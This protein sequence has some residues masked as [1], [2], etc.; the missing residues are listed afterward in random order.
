MLRRIAKAQNYNKKA[1]VI[2]EVIYFPIEILNLV[3]KI[4]NNFK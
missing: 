1:L 4:V 2:N 3:K